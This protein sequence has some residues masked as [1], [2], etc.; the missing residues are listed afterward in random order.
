[1]NK[2]IKASTNFARVQNGGDR[3]VVVRDNY[4]RRLG[5][6]GKPVRNYG[7]ID[8]ALKKGNVKNRMKARV[9]RREF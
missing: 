5:S 9:L 7:G 1:M 6:V 2:I 3:K 4:D 8:I